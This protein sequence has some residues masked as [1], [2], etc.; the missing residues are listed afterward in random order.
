MKDITFK[1]LTDEQINAIKVLLGDACEIEEQIEEKEEIPFPKKA[2]KFYFL[3]SDG[4]IDYAYYSPTSPIHADRIS[5]GNCFRTEEEAEFEV[6][7]R[8]VIHEMKKFAELK[9][10]KWDS[11]NDHHYIYYH[12]SDLYDNNAVLIG[13]ANTCKSDEIYFKSEE[14]AKACIEAV[15]EDRIKKY[16][17]ETKELNNDTDN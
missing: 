6:E 14:D 5:I 3:L 1:N 16:Y 12:F 9:N 2:D 17:F 15:G 11:F 4:G 13:N 8:K 10:Y 7:R